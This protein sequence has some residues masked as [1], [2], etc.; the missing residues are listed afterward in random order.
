MRTAALLAPLVLAA[1]AAVL[2]DE[3]APPAAPEPAPVT[4]EQ[5]DE[6]LKRALKTLDDDLAK[7]FSAYEQQGVF[8]SAVAGWA[9]LLL[10]ERGE[11]A[12]PMPA[13]SKSLARLAGHVDQYLQKVER[14]LDRGG[15]PPVPGGEVPRDLE[16]MDLNDGMQCNWPAAAAGLFFA[17]ALQRGKLRAEAKAACVRALKILEATQQEDGGWG[18]DDGRRGGIGGVTLPI[19]DPTGRRGRLDY[20]KTL[21]STSNLCATAVAA[22]RR[23]LK[24]E[25]G[26]SVKK[27]RAYYLAAQNSDGSYPYDPS[28]TCKEREGFG[29]SEMPIEAPLT[30]GALLA[31]RSLGAGD[32][33]CAA[34]ALAFVEAQTANL[35][36]GHGSA[37]YGLMLSALEASQRGEAAWKTFRGHHLRRLLDAQGKSGTFACACK[38]GSFGTTCDTEPLPGGVEFPGHDEDSRMYVTALHTLILALD[39]TPSKALPPPAKPA[40]AAPVVTP[41]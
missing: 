40:P 31:I 16:E 1:A 4:A 9:F 39:R 6:A 23:A 27:A 25:G 17:E 30:A 13:R 3:P 28:Q 21:L 10:E 14:F 20:P 11:A 35:S 32:L 38:H 7:H 22:L 8:A 41:R 26:E 36:E 33:P 37:S 19:P 34:K 12:A 2:A 29:P 5:R 24:K 18:H 15:K